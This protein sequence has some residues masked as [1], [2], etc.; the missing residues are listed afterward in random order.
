[1]KEARK[2]RDENLRI[3]EK[4]R[5]E[6]ERKEIQDSINN[7]ENRSKP[8]DEKKQTPEERRKTKEEDRLNPF[9]LGQNESPKSWRGKKTVPRIPIPN[10]AN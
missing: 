8:E 3:K 1:M 10:L 4:E 2:Q 9:A 5:Q 7:S 6:K